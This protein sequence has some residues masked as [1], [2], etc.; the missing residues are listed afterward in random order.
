VAHVPL[1][2]AHELGHPVA[3]LVLMEADDGALHAAS[4]RR[5]VTRVVSWIGP[6]TP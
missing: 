2:A 5:A 1:M 6:S 4:V 3:F